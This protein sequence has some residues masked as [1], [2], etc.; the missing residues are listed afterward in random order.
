MQLNNKIFIVAFTSYLG[1]VL[2][3]TVKE[4]LVLNIGSIED[5]A[6]QIDLADL[7]IKFI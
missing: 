6:T 3:T 7:K 2:K 1:K 5:I 4:A